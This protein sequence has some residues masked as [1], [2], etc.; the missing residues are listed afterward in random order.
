MQSSEKYE[1]YI[2][3]LLSKQF[4]IYV[5]QTRNQSTQLKPI[6]YRRVQINYP[7]KKVR[8]QIQQEISFE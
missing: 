1:N 8:Y 7:Y 3:G 4:F 2:L 5:K 6:Q